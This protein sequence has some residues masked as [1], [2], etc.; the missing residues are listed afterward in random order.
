VGEKVEREGGI[1]NEDPRR[2][3]RVLFDET[4]QLR[5]GR[6]EIEY[7]G[8]AKAM[9]VAVVGGGIAG[10]GAAF[11]GDY[12]INSTVGQAHFSGLQAANALLE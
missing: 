12:L 9:R 11:A 3:G 8:G 2:A 1:V 7:R 6:C 5:L 10:A 4:V